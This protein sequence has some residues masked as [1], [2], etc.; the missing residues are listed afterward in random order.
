MNLN[1][2]FNES[3]NTK[4]EFAA[5]KS[6]ITLNELD[7]SDEWGNWTCGNCSQLC[8]NSG[9]MSCTRECINPPSGSTCSG[10]NTLTLS[11]PNTTCPGRYLFFCWYFYAD[12][13]QQRLYTHMLLVSIL[14]C[15]VHASRILTLSLTRVK[16]C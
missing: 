8:G 15:L 5:K 16:Y 1:A 12:R 2:V 4:K 14:F 10:P 3:Y 11:C 6:E 13:S 9:V 7:Y